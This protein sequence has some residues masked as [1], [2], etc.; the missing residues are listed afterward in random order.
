MGAPYRFEA[1][2]ESGEK[3]AWAG[4]VNARALSSSGEL[5]LENILLPKYAPYYAH[6]TQAVNA[7]RPEEQIRVGAHPHE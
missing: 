2:T 6:L 4:T 1:R 3:L 7:D 5:T